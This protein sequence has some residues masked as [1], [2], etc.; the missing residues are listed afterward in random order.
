MVSINFDQL[1]FAW[2]KNGQENV[3]RLFMENNSHFEI[4]IWVEGIYRILR[5]RFFYVKYHKIF[6]IEI[7]LLYI[8]RR[9]IILNK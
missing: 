4:L 1:D 9:S 5:F 6:R 3:K 8:S 2:T 7:F